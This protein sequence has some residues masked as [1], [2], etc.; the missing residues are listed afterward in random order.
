VPVE[1]L[2]PTWID[3]LPQQIAYYY[4]GYLRVSEEFRRMNMD[5]KQG[6]THG[7]N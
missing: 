1:K 6:L 7:I 3:D 4:V 2:L 5:H